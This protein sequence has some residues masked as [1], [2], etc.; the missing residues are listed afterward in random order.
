M[1]KPCF[2]VTLD[3]NLVVLQVEHATKEESGQATCQYVTVS[4]RFILLSIFV[5][6]QN[7]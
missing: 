3:M 4:P 5:Y 6:S 1:I 2:P 7:C